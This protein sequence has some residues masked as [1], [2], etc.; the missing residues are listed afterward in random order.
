MYES[1]MERFNL[2][3]AHLQ[4]FSFD[5]YFTPKTRVS[6]RS[7]RNH[8]SKDSFQEDDIKTLIKFLSDKKLNLI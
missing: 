8:F 4:A 7:L 2:Q 3:E 6:S 1:K 5:Q